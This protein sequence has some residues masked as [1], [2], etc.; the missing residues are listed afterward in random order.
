[1]VRCV[2]RKYPTA[3]IDFLVKKQFS[4]LVAHNPYL[5][6]V[7]VYEKGEKLK[8]LKRKIK[9]EKYDWVIDIHQNLRS[10]YLKLGLNAPLVTGYCKQLVHRSLLVYLG[11]NRYREVKP[12]LLRYFEAVEKQGVAYDGSGTEVFIPEDNVETMRRTLTQSG[13][14]ADK[15]LYVIGPG[16]SF[17]NKRWSPEGYAKVAD[18]L[19]NN[20]NGFVAFIGGGSDARL[21]TRIQDLASA[22]TAN[23][24]GAFSIVES[25]ALLSL[26]AAFI[27]NDSGM[28]HLAQAFG[29]PVVGIFGPTVKELGYF[30]MA[31]RSIVVEKPIQCRPCTHNG[32]NHCP[33][34][35]FLCMT[36][37]GS[38]DVIEAVNN[39][40]AR[41]FDN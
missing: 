20:H 21:C 40:L 29:K 30:P 39:L 1:M 38:D 24:A 25:A 5:S 34:R 3:R 13:Y 31:D 6:N 16:A 12:V 35:H 22:K 14:T 23:F 19:I 8:I 36:A 10:H 33:K 17:T 32:L 15:K 28:L 18:H 4:E 9:D 2:R 7:L 11:I 26:C 37:I 27:G 41:H